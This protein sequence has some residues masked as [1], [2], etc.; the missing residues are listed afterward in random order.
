MAAKLLHILHFLYLT[1]TTWLSFKLKWHAVVM[2]MMYCFRGLF[3]AQV[4]C[5]CGLQFL[6]W[7]W[8]PVETKTRF[9]PSH[10]EITPLPLS[11]GLKSHPERSQPP[12][13][14][15]KKEARLQQKGSMNLNKK[16]A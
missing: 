1:D 10:L 8:K 12:H 11:A 2:S 15:V 13:R 3:L 5:L 9:E 6:V 14:S 4:S 16:N 7:L